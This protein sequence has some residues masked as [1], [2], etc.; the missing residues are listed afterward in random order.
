MIV[1]KKVGLENEPN[2]VAT[3]L[4]IRCPDVAG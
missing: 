3:V 4:E 1:F 2:S